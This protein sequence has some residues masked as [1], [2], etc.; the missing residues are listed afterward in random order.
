MSVISAPQW[1]K[2]AL[3]GMVQT[4]ID[5]MK[6]WGLRFAGLLF[7][8]LVAPIA[9]FVFMV[10]TVHEKF[11]AM[12]ATAIEPGGMV[13]SLSVTS[14]LAMANSFFPIDDI[15]ILLPVLISLSLA[16]Y[17]YRLVKS[18]IPTMS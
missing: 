17:T 11:N 2:N 1:L 15:V 16:A 3:G 18:F 6:G 14:M 13:T 7:M 5:F 8:P 10:T 4:L 9:F 12:L